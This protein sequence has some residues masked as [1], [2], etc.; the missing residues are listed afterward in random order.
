MRADVHTCMHTLT[1]IRVHTCTLRMGVSMHVSMCRPLREVTY[2]SASPRGPG[3][4]SYPL[5]LLRRVA[6]IGGQGVRGGV[7]VRSEI[8][9]KYE[10]GSSITKGYTLFCNVL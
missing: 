5:S 4:G 1:Y 9:A 8:T 3:T 6:K 10:L 2:V 7:R